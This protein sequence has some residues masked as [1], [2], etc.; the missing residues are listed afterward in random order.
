MKKIL[1]ICLLVLANFT[2]QAVNYVDKVQA[3]NRCKDACDVFQKAF[4]DMETNKTLPGIMKSKYPKMVADCNV[5]CASIDQ[6][7]PVNK[8]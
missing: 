3:V 1:Y 5:K 8:N 4:K 6:L 7:K 2:I